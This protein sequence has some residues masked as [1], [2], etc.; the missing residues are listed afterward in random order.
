MLTVMII[1][2][3]LRFNTTE[4]SQELYEVVEAEVYWD[5]GTVMGYT[6][7]VLFLYLLMVRP[8][9]SSLQ[10]TALHCTAV[11]RQVR[12]TAACGQGG[13]EATLRQR[14]LGERCTSV[15]GRSIMVEMLA[16]GDTREAVTR[17]M[18]E[19]AYPEEGEQEEQGEVREP[20]EVAR[21]GREGDRRR[22]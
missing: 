10:C 22:Q 20:K 9:P 3:V 4:N 13:L 7:F 1:L 14:W 16:S 6:V 8:P 21:G 15:P 12:G 2:I 5:M 11:V 17:T 18:E 19:L